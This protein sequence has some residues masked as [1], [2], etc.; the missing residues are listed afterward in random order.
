MLSLEIAGADKAKA[1]RFMEALQLCLPATTLGDVYTLV[2]H[3][4]TSS[5]RSFSEA[6]L[7]KVGISQGLVRCSVGI[8][9]AGDIIAD[10]EQALARV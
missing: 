1:F 4:A 10:F 5:H 6:A 3:P 7:A 9:D 2:L 8:E